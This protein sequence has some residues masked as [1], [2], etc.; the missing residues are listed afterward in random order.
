MTF[1]VLEDDDVRNVWIG[2]DEVKGSQPD[3]VLL[4]GN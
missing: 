4:F 1:S 2:I 3:S